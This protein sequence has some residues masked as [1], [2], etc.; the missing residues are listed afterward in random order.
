[1]LAFTLG[2]NPWLWLLFFVVVLFATIVVLCVIIG[3]IIAWAAARYSDKTIDK[4]TKEIL[5]LMPCTDCG[6]C[7]RHTCEEFADA[8]L[9]TEIDEDA[10]PYIDEETINK[11]LAMRE[12]LQ[13][14]MEDPTPPKKR[15]P[16]FW[17]QKF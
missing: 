11:I 17:E 8:I 14:S 15:E 13:K 3:L 5:K 12:R 6:E 16:R 10:C 9:H 7:K 4:Y 1:M 2:Y